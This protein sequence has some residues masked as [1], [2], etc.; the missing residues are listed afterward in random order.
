MPSKPRTLAGILRIR[1]HADRTYNLV[2]R[3]PATARIHGSARW[4][5]VRAQVLR[6]EP[7]CRSCALTGRSE[8]ATT[9]D[10]IVGV[11][12][13][14]ER[15]YD[16]TNL[17]PLCTSCHA[18]KSASERR[19]TGVDPGVGG[20]RALGARRPRAARGGR[21]DFHGYRETPE[22]PWKA[23]I[24]G[25]FCVHTTPPGGPDRCP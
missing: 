21:P 10:H 24:S 23:R 1:R 14:P 20:S 6:N 25:L 16:P 7:V 22:T 13:A 15:A 18:W 19:G 17:Q 2:Q 5:D 4:Q 9:V 11:A 3:D 12:L 8:P